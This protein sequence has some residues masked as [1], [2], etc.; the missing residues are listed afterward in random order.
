MKFIDEA[1]ITVSSG[2]GGNG[3]IGFRREKFVPKGGP[4][5][6]DGGIGGSIYFQ[7][8]E[9][10]NTLLC[11]R[12]KK[13]YKAGRG[14]D[15][16]KARMSGRYGEDIIL[17]VPVGTLIKRADTSKVIVDLNRHEQKVLI[18]Q[19]GRGG[20][21]NVN[22]KSSTNQTPRYAEQ[23]RPG[24]SMDLDLELKILADV[25][26]IGVPNAGKSTLISTLS[27]A[28]PKVADYPFTTLNPSL[29]I[30]KIGDDS[31]TM[32]DIPG[33]IKDASRGKGLGIRFLK[34]IERAKMF[35]HLVDISWC[36]DEYE[37]FEQYCTVRDE[38]EKYN[39]SLLDK[40]EIVCLTKVDALS[41]EEVK[42][43]VLAFEKQLQ[44]KVLPLSSVSGHHLGQ[45]KSLMYKALS[46][47]K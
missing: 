22:F 41:D 2:A 30:V 40:K 11:Y 44:K 45:L 8:E 19:G 3:C 5:G 13:L 46:L 42:K 39:P 21:G 43:F 27:A 37:A 9:G 17:K 1:K 24:I 10:V 38:L 26:I 35:V 18:A 12:G 32:A 25:A 15:G 16:G 28:K 20:R 7:A 36:L 47:S 23:G 34:H 29:G 33:L 4:D 6:G 14:E 31:L